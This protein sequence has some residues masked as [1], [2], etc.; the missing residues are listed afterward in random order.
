MLNNFGMNKDWLMLTS[1]ADR[2][3]VRQLSVACCFIETGKVFCTFFVV[4]LR[5]LLLQFVA[6]SY[7]AYVIPLKTACKSFSQLIL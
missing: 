7:T 1:L 5:V 6:F 4:V 2:E 3:A